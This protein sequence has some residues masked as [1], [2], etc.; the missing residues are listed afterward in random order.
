MFLQSRRFRTLAQSAAS[1]QAMELLP[2][3]MID[4]EMID[5]EMLLLKQLGGSWVALS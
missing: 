3:E 2:G 1:V 5:G 4:G